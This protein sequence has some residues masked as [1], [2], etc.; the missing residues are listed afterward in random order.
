MSPGNRKLLDSFSTLFN[1]YEH[2]INFEA[3]T[4]CDQKEVPNFILLKKA[5]DTL[6]NNLY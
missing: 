4:Y 1:F 5:V 3:D 6:F 2:P